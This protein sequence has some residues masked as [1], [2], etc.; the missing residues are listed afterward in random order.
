MQQHAGHVESLE[1]LSFINLFVGLITTNKPY[2]LQLPWQQLTRLESLNASCIGLTLIA[3]SQ[4]AQQQD[5]QQLVLP[6]LKHLELKGCQLN[7]PRCLVALGSTGL[8]SLVL[9][10]SH[11]TGDCEE[12]QQSAALATLLAR[13]PSLRVLQLPRL[14]LEGAV[15]KQVASLPCLQDLCLTMGEGSD[16]ECLVDLPS[17]MT[18]LVLHD[19]R[20]NHSQL[21]QP[22]LPSK[23]HQLSSLLALHM[24]GWTFAPEALRCV[25]A[26]RHLHVS[27][28]RM[29]P[30]EPHSLFVASE[31]AT[32]AL[33]GALKTLTQLQH[34]ELRAL[35]LRTDSTSTPPLEFAEQWS[36]ITASTQLTQ[37]VLFGSGKPPLP[38]P[39]LGVPHAFAAGRR[40]PHLQILELSGSKCVDGDHLHSIVTCCPALKQL[41]LDGV[42]YGAAAADVAALA[43]LPHSLTRLHIAGDAFTDTVAVGALKQ[44][45]NL[46]SLSWVNSPSVSVAAVEQ[47]TVLQQLTSLK[48]L[49]R[50]AHRDDSTASQLFWD[51]NIYGFGPIESMDCEVRGCAPA[52]GLF[53][54]HHACQ[55]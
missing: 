47:L 20:Y 26:L 44:L 15:V 38:L 9:E 31:S 4:P 50:G 32:A 40:L 27:S 14:F 46:K 3:G 5:N 2:P 16:G 6:R 39:L 21:A 18:K 48:V 11:F 23:P 17:C 1:V 33:L 19:Y 37:L 13:L 22:T 49:Q 25:P 10:L 42:M 53:A 30:Y 54:Y 36:A 8:T 24:D 34:L 41:T 51:D 55:R 43:R 45:S 7:S 35:G 28:C 12:E 29:P 52:C